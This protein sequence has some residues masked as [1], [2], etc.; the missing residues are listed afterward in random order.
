VLQIDAPDLVRVYGRRL[1]L[2]T[3]RIHSAWRGAS[4]DDPTVA[5]GI[6]ARVLGWSESPT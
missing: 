4:C 6:I 3:P 5:D 1:L 2:V